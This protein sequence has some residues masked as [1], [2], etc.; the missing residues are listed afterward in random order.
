MAS[1]ERDVPQWGRSLSPSSRSNFLLGS[2]SLRMYALASRSLKMFDS[3]AGITIH[4]AAPSLR[5]ESVNGGVN[6]AG[7][8]RYRDL[9]ASGETL[10]GSMAWS[11]SQAEVEQGRSGKL[12]QTRASPS[13]TSNPHTTRSR[14]FDKLSI[15][16]AVSG[17][18][19]RAGSP[20][21]A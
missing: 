20:R 1:R 11:L 4:G 21:Y 17:E 7:E 3:R 15:E 10:S 5:D 9:V 2:W 12:R 6:E 13:P 8:R 14:S 16:R 19:R 18:C